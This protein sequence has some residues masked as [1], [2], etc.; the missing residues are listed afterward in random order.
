MTLETIGLFMLVGMRVMG[1]LLA[2]PVFSHK[3]I[4]VMARITL[5]CAFALMAMPIVEPGFSLPDSLWMLVLWFGKELVVGALMGLAIRMI[6]FIL[7]F[8]AYVITVEIGL[9]PGPEFD[10]STASSQGNPLGT[11]I[12]FLG[13]MILL[14]GSEYDMLLA[15]MRSFDVAPVGYIEANP[16]AAEYLIERTVDIFVIGIL[17]A[18]PFTAVNFLVNLIFAVL[19]K[20]VP[21][22]NVFILSFSVR[23]F[24]GTMVLTLTVGLIAH[25]T[26]NYIAETPE[27][28]LRFILFRPQA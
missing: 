1:L 2:A 27:M 7:D 26:V 17:I 22:L 15:F 14:S 3:R 6:F 28:M 16:F 12:Y 19:G 21:K 11:I 9:Q 20:V 8:A 18:A 5:A 24:F 13:I 25:Y 10:P 23:I 4:P